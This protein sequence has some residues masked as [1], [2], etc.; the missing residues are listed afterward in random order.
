VIASEKSAEGIVGG[1]STEG[2]N[3]RKREVVA[4]LSLFAMRQNPVA[5]GLLAKLMGEARRQCEPGTE[6]N[7]ATRAHETPAMCGHIAQSAEPPYADPH[8]RWCGRGGDAKRSSPLSRF[9]RPI[10]RLQWML[11]RNSALESGWRHTFVTV[12]QANDI[13]FAEIASHLH[14]D[15]SQGLFVPVFKA[16]LHTDRNEG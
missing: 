3:G 5:S 15:D 4:C 2:L 10:S 14:L 13:V 1:Q 7:V 12:L 11:H 16:M 6:A 8:V 9:E